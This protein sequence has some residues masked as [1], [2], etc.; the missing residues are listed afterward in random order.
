MRRISLALV[1]MMFV[2]SCG[3]DE[4]PPG[5]PGNGGGSGAEVSFTL[6]PDVPS[7]S[8]TVGGAH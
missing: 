1:S 2:L 8:G 4:P 7:P 6:T 5:G 3:D